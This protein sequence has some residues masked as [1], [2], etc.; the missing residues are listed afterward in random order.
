MSAIDLLRKNVLRGEGGKGGKGG[1]GLGFHDMSWVP[2]SIEYVRSSISP[3]SVCI[4]RH[5]LAIWILSISGDGGGSDDQLSLLPRRLHRL[6]GLIM[7]HTFGV[8][9]DIECSQAIVFT[10]VVSNSALL[11]T[12]IINVPAVACT[13]PPAR[14][15]QRKS[16]K[17][18]IDPS[19][20][21]SLKV[22]KVWAVSS[23]SAALSTY[24]LVLYHNMRYY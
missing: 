11:L 1:G 18:S 8:L 2:T 16:M 6:I 23:H 13:A 7:L 9:I 4:Y 12:L 22:P 21:E 17:V 24:L 10:Y 15:Y 20:L 19:I 5:L 14:L 3:T